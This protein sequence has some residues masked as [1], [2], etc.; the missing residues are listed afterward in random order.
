[1]LCHLRRFVSINASNTVSYDFCLSFL[2][3]MLD[4]PPN[5]ICTPK[6]QGGA[7]LSKLA[8]FAKNKQT[9]K[10]LFCFWSGRS[11]RVEARRRKAT[12]WLL[13]RRGG[14]KRAGCAAQ[15]ASKPAIVCDARLSP[16]PP[17]IR[18]AQTGFLCFTPLQ[19]T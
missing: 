17:K 18:K 10:G 15:S 8:F 1:M 3:P 13:S 19:H 7:F 2:T 12:V 11:K 4:A 16:P 14:V 9:R 5:A 6:T